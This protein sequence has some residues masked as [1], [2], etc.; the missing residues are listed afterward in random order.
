MASRVEVVGDRG[1]TG[2]RV[3]RIGGGAGVLSPPIVVGGET[4]ADSAVRVQRIENDG[5]V[6]AALSWSLL[7]DG[8]RL[9]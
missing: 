1:G 9:L 8:L 7:L 4:A 3:N 5:D 2:A 6:L